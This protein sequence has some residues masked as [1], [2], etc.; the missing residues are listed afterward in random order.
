[1]GLF[2][3]LE[4]TLPCRKCNKA[5]LS[6]VQFK[7]GDDRNLPIYAVGDSVKLPA[8]TEYEGLAKAYCPTCQAEWRSA[9][10]SAHFQELANSVSAGQ[11]NAEH[12]GRP[13]SFEDVLLL[14]KKRHPYPGFPNFPARLMALGVK[15][16]W[17]WH[18]HFNMIEEHLISQGWPSGAFDSFEVTVRVDAAGLL[19]LGGRL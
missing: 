16:E 19:T 11:A 4:A 1:M 7:T 12:D 15:V 2:S 10:K 3:T 5:F 8:D 18:T 6:E 13:L 17:S 14:S 9:E